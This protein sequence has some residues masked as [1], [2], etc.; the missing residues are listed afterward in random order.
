M[1]VFTIPKMARVYFLHHRGLLGEL[2]RAAYETVKEL[3]AAAASED[4]SF[5]PGMVSVVQTFG[6]VAKFNPH[7]HA[8]CSRGGW[9]TSGEW[10]ALPYID[11][12]KS[13]G[14]ISLSCVSLAQGQRIIE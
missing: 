7:I 6:N 2:S 12:Q 8:L 4:N 10:I 3:R 9:N 5:R 14:V 13:G 11:T 1:W